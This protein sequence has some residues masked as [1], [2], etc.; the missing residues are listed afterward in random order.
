MFLWEVGGIGDKDLYLGIVRF[1]EHG[2]ERV[3]DLMFRALIPILAGHG[4]CCSTY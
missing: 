4:V 1:T 2:D 3:A